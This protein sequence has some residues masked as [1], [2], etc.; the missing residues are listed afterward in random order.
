MLS[1][2]GR[3]DACPTQYR[4]DSGASQYRQ[5]TGATHGRRGMTLAE[6]AIATVLVGTMLVADTAVA[7]QV[8]LPIPFSVRIAEVRQSDRH[9]VFEMWIQDPD[10][11]PFDVNWVGYNAARIESLYPPEP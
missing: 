7:K 6:A 4:Q 1:Q 5:D 3:Q 8:L 11:G 2:N 9:K 10:G